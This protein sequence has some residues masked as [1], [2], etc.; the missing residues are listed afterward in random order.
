MHQFYLES[1]PLENKNL[2]TDALNK[3]PN[4]LLSSHRIFSNSFCNFVYETSSL[5]QFFYDEK[6]K[7]GVYF[8]GFLSEGPSWLIPKNSSPDNLQFLY[9]MAK[10]ISTDEIYRC[11]GQF[12]FLIFNEKNQETICFTS[13]LSNIRIFHSHF[14]KKFILSNCLGT[15]H[16]MERSILDE[17]N[18]QALC[19]FLTQ[20]RIVGSQ[21]LF[22]NISCLPLL[23]KLTHK[24][25]THIENAIFPSW[26]PEAFES[27]EEAASRIFLTFKNAVEIWSQRIP[28]NSI[29][30]SGGVDSRAIVCCLPENVRK[31]TIFTTTVQPNLTEFTDRDAFLAKKV[32]DLFCLNHRWVKPEGPNPSYSFLIAKAPYCPALT[33]CT[34][35]EFLG[36]LGLK[37]STL[38]SDIPELT[39]RIAF[40]KKN[41][42]FT[43]IDLQSAFFEAEAEIHTTKKN[44]TLWNEFRSLH[45]A[46]RSIRDSL[47]V[48]TWAAP[49]AFSLISQSPFWDSNFIEA[50]LK[51]RIEYIQNAKLY[52]KMF[53]L[54]MP[55]ALQL[56]FHSHLCDF[57]PQTFRPTNEGIHPKTDAALAHPKQYEF[58][59]LDPIK[60]IF[61]HHFKYID[62]PEIPDH[63]KFVL[64][65]LGTMYSD[66]KNPIFL[67]SA[68]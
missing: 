9:K 12:V 35:G 61:K 63:I 57:Q 10:E 59:F 45:Y 43:D 11:R 30:L 67:P 26:E 17:V 54:F 38:P 20:G 31:K 3:L 32:A 41:F 62:E 60:D 16:F 23:S 64:N 22:K 19:H 33:G 24:K 53:E 8:S 21:T 47:T 4:E 25:S 51:T 28:L 27:L 34:G 39:D 58:Q 65:N 56:P 52:A 29:N 6:N 40:L 46:T 66:L 44:E 37:I 5:T 18:K 50:V 15:I 14:E 2:H 36:G 55:E 49:Y 48:R 42:N 1:F 68:I 13:A 7:I